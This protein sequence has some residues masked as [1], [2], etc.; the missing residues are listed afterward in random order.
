MKMRSFLLIF[1]VSLAICACENPLMNSI[2]QSKTITFE[3]NGGSH[4]PSQTLLKNEKISEPRAPTKAGFF[5]GG[6]F[7]EDV[8]YFYRWNFNDIPEGDMT[9]YAAWSEKPTPTENDFIIKGAEHVEYDG[10]PKAVTI[11]VYQGKTGGK[12]TVYYEGTQDTE[13]ERTQNAPTSPGTYIVTFDVAAVEGWNAANNLYAGIMTIMMSVKVNQTPVA[14]DFN[15]GGAFTYTYDGSSKSVSIEPKKGK[16]QGTLTVYYNG[17]TA[18][19]VNIGTY[20]VTFDVA[21]ADGWYAA[22]GLSAGTLT[23]IAANPNNQTPAAGDYTISGNGTFIYD[24]GAKAVT[25][26]PK[27]GKSQGTIIIKY[28]GNITAPTN[29]GTYNVTFDVAAVSGWNSASGLSAGTITIGKAAPDAEDFYISGAGT[30]YY[31]GYAKAVTITPKNGKSP[32]NITVKYNN[33]TDEPIDVGTYV[34]TY[35]VAESANWN[36]VHGLFAGLLTINKGT[37]TADNYTISGLTQTYDGEA[38]SVSIMP[39]TNTIPGSVIIYYNNNTTAP[40]NAGDYTVTF[41]VAADTNGNW[42]QANGLSAGTLT[43][44]KATPVLGDY[45]ISNNLTQNVPYPDSSNISAVTVTVKTNGISS[46]G[47]VTVYYEGINGTTYTKN[48]TKPSNIGSYAVTFNVEGNANWNAANGLVAETLKIN[49]FESIYDLKVWLV[50]LD[51][52]SLK[53]PYPVALNV[54]NLGG[55]YRTEGSA[56]K[57]LID[58]HETYGIFVSLDLSG[59]SFT[60]IEANAFQDCG[61]LI[62]VIIS[63]NVISIGTSAFA[64]CGNLTSVIIGANVQSIGNIAFYDINDISVTFRNDNTSLGGEAFYDVNGLNALYSTEGAGT[65]NLIDNKW[66]KQ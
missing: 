57:M 1:L 8:Y 38:K 39:K 54:D 47:D 51:E 21:P 43:I 58:I 46:P 26:T 55:D 13:Y 17:N 65:Y 29:A 37:L 28:N 34:V 50:S 59:S 3:S 7:M 18:L 5:F 9:L 61:N 36:A 6:W 44:N 22:N 35:D 4:V 60:S 62:D 15:I 52:N 31:N 19:P 23:I 63:D 49:V 25:V 45:D 14:G 56:G 32:G 27:T 53:N 66:T 33:N 11:T 20:A 41:D 16:S 2:L 10:N 64:S 48:T 42:N 24:G 30:L 40:V 12:I